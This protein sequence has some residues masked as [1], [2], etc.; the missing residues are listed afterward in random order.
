LWISIWGEGEIPL[1]NLARALEEGTEVTGV[2]HL[3]YRKGKRILSTR[4]PHGPYPP[5]DSYPFADHSDYFNSFP[6]LHLQSSARI[7]I[8]GSRSCSWN[9]CKFCVINEEFTHRERSPENI[10]N[11][12][13]Y[14]SNKYNVDAFIF[15]DSDVAGNE[16]RFKK[17]LTLL[18]H[19][20]ER[21]RRPYVFFSE[22]SPL[23][24]S[25]QAA[26]YMKFASLTR[27]QVGFE[28]MTDSLL[29]KM[30]KR[31]RFAHN[32][33]ALKLGNQ[34][35]LILEG[36]NIIRG[37]PGE[38]KEDVM[39]SA[40]NLRFLRFLLNRFD[41][42][43]T[44]FTLF[45]EA[46]FYREMPEEERKTWNFEPFWEVIS[47]MKI[48]PESERFEFLGF[49]TDRFSHY[50]QWEEFE[51]EMKNYKRE[52]LSYEWLEYSNSSLVEERGLKSRK[53]T[54]NRDETDIL[55]YCDSIKTFSA[56]KREFS[57]LS[58][59]DLLKMMS[60]LKT[61]G[62]LY[63]DKTLD[64]IIAVMEAGRRKTIDEW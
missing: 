58:E 59:D 25:P 31:H 8:W 54:L 7:P 63:Y 10:V 2:P 16:K 36:L 40:A 22:I 29:E 27:A 17:L 47:Q 53:Y 41:F 55:I 38:T 13:E 43:L 50:Y 62:L 28:A 20:V 35:G 14:Q 49:W 56:V 44:H 52:N 5:L 9:R 26:K 19:S 24:I 57:H 32:I 48:I 4:T 46:P 23:F 18:M 21:R 64:T 11:E 34:Y 61:N 42:N 12:I 30:Q 39:E 6:Q 51:T 45:K 37:I 15:T 33:Q 1:V 60:T 3:A